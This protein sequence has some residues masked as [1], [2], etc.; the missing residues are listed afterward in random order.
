MLTDHMTNPM[1]PKADPTQYF[2]RYQ[3]PLGEDTIH[4][5]YSDY[6]KQGNDYRPLGPI[7]YNRKI[8]VKVNLSRGM[9]PGFYLQYFDYALISNGNP[10]SLQQAYRDHD[11]MEFGLFS[12]VNLPGLRA[13]REIPQHLFIWSM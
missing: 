5:Y 3:N 12:E 6:E 7:P 13:P 8:E 11:Q 4:V 9:L 10:H 2:E 1:H